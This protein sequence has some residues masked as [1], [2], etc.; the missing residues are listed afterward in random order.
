M[1]RTQ[2]LEQTVT[3]LYAAH[4]SERA[5]WADWL[6]ENHVFLVADNATELAQRYGANVELA[7]AG[8][9]LHD[10]ADFVYSEYGSIV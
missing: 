10:I 3:D 8:V 4:N 2:T 6:G 7:R 9:L 5:E 1:T